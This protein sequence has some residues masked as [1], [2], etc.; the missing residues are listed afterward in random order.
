MQNDAE[1]ESGGEVVIEWVLDMKM[2][3]YSLNWTLRKDI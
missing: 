2:D 1:E 3:R